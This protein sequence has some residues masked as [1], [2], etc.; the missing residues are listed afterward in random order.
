MTLTFLT[1]RNSLKI[2]RN[3]TEPRPEAEVPCAV[4]TQGEIRG[5]NRTK[6]LKAVP[7]TSEIRG[8]IEQ[9]DFLVKDLR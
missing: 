1:L 4:L 9:N 8:R 5:E 2:E 6:M 7:T 3:S